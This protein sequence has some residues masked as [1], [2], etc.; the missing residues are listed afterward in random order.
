MATPEAFIKAFQ[1]NHL[2]YRT[3]RNASEIA[4]TLWAETQQIDNLLKARLA[5]Y[6]NSKAS[7]AAI[8][9]MRTGSLLSKDLSPYIKGEDVVQDSEVLTT[10]MVVVPMVNKQD[11]QQSYEQLAPMV[12]PRSSRLI[13]E[14][15]GY[16]LFNVTIFVKH[17]SEFVK[18]AS[19]HKF[20]VREFKYDPALYQETMATNEAMQ[21]DLEN[22][23]SSLVR[24][25]KTNFGEV[26]SAWIHLKVLRLF[27][28]SVLC[29]GLPPQFLAVVL[30]PSHQSG[31][32]GSTG[33]KGEKKLRVALLQSLEQL[34]LPGI[35]RFDVTT[36][37]HQIK[38][39][40]SQA[41]ETAEEAELWMALNMASQDQDPF[42][43]VV[44]NWNL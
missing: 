31:G 10:L 8:E 33:S 21:V 17:R 29:Y 32:F 35:S 3:D 38:D 18:N 6:N 22:Q 36:A 12:V 7:V 30:R 9:R 44:I 39:S 40:S 4:E 41:H 13:A 1:W 24:L 15:D 37:L 28:E 43:K 5:T 25:L 19:E 26:F 11:W 27:V 42:V 34:A 14:E 2:K 23:W 20:I 16:C